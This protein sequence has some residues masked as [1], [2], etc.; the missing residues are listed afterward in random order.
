MAYE[1][2]TSTTEG[3]GEWFSSR[4]GGIL[5]PIAASGMI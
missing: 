1:P 5:V 3:V 4:I 2:R